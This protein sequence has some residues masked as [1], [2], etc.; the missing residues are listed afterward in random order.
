M[1]NPDRRSAGPLPM[2][3]PQPELASRQDWRSSSPSGRAKLST[4]DQSNRSVSGRKDTFSH[5]P[6]TSSPQTPSTQHPTMDPAWAGVPDMQQWQAFATQTNNLGAL[7]EAYGA[8]HGQ[9]HAAHDGLDWTHSPYGM[10]PPGNPAMSPMMAG[11]PGIQFPVSPAQP[12]SVVQSQMLLQQQQHLQKQQQQLSQQQQ[13]LQQQDDQVALQQ[14]MLLAQIQAIQDMRAQN[15]PQA[16]TPPMNQELPQ[17]SKMLFGSS[18]R[19][20]TRGSPSGASSATTPN[21]VRSPLQNS[22]GEHRE[23]SPSVGSDRFHQMQLPPDVTNAMASM[24]LIRQS[25]GQSS[26]STPAHPSQRPKS[27]GGREKRDSDLRMASFG[28][29]GKSPDVSRISTPPRAEQGGERSSRNLTPSIIINNAVVAEAKERGQ[30]RPTRNSL[31]GASPDTEHKRRSLA[32]LGVGRAPR[33]TEGSGDQAQQQ[34]VHYP[35]RQPRGPP[36]ESFFA[37]NFLAR[38]SIRTRREAMT[39]LCA[40]PRAP[41]FSGKSATAAGREIS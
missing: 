3:A 35:R 37:N 7:A 15:K 13:Q 38:R 40:S 2:Q 18:P 29:S 33:N 26:P 11:V 28:A 12:M 34:I 22:V 21:R 5:S 36:M 39:K 14:Q 19:R 1:S 25:Q 31:A 32:E 17:N 20:G 24:N 30:G 23:P 4:P 8:S 10:L 6:R 16:E 27:Y 9:P 41:S